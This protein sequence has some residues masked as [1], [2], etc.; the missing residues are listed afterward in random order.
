MLL[1]QTFPGDKENRIHFLSPS[2]SPT[3][4]RKAA[5]V[6]DKQRTKRAVSPISLVSSD[7]EYKNR[8]AMKRKVLRCED[9]EIGHVS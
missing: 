5:S 1:F 3:P 4:V 7:G 6:S 9:V 8:T 2:L